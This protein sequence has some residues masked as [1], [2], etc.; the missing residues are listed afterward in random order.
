MFP[1]SLRKSLLALSSLTLLGLTPVAALSGTAEAQQVQAH[2]RA[3]AWD[4]VNRDYW[5]TFA[6]GLTDRATTSGSVKACRPGTLSSTDRV[7]QQNAINFVRRLNHLSPVTT[8]NATLNKKAQ[9]AA[10]M[11]AANKTLS[12]F[13]DSSWKC[14]STAGAQGAGTSN[15]GLGYRLGDAQWVRL[16]MGDPGSG[17]EAV[18]HRRWLLY[19]PITTMG[20]GAIE[21]GSGVA[22]SAITVLGTP[23]S[24]KANN[25]AW[26]AWPSAG[27]FPNTL[28]SARWSLTAAEAGAKFDS[29]TVKVTNLATHKAVAVKPLTPQYGYGNPTLVWTMPSGLDRTVSYGV[30]VDGISGASAASHSYVVRFFTPKKP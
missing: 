11:M 3:A 24:S 8:N 9:A 16:Y 1:H 13:P 2:H 20:V 6:V 23:Q 14:Y 12:H 27:W 7:R 21:D 25:P 30:T 17:N 22:G 10:L 19:P 29:A 26:V 18:G 28:N 5:K 4:S 15:I